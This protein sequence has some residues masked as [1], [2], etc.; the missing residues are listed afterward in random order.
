MKPDQTS[1]AAFQ[2]VYMALAYRYN[3]W[4]RTK[5]L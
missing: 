1:P 4:F 5:L 3:Q 2:F